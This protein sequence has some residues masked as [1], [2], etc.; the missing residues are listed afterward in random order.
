[1]NNCFEGFLTEHCEGCPWWADG[2]QGKGLGC[3]TPFPI[4]AC[5]HF[6]EMYDNDPRNKTD[7]N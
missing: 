1:M 5:P 3:A 4:M 6:K 2:T 7:N